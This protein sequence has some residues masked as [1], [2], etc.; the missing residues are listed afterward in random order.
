[1]IDWHRVRELREEVGADDFPEVAGLF[2]E[3]SDE[4]IAQLRAGACSVPLQDR[5]HF[6]KGSALNLGFDRL[7]KLCTEG[8]RLA[9]AGEAGRFPLATLIATYDASRAEL[10]AGDDAPSA[11][12]PVR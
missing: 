10:V 6:L 2:L 11:A 9:E 7:A 5:L 1:M 4:V 12:P 3:E 8:V